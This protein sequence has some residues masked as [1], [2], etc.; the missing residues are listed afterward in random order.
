MKI[1]LH[2][3]PLLGAAILLA[4]ATGCKSDTRADIDRMV[5]EL[6]S[7]Q[8]KSKEI[9]TGLFTDSEVALKS[10]TL[11][12]TF[13]CAPSVSL[14][15]VTPEK[16]PALREISVADF[17]AALSVPEMRKGMEALRD[18]GMMLLM[19]WKDSAGHDVR[20]QIPPSE[21]LGD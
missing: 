7:P 18:N 10:D 1:S 5:T 8:F 14:A 9:A 2:L 15:A 12:F 21:I 4:T 3:L 17:K 19:V 6:N 13:I 16:L 20:I 11:F